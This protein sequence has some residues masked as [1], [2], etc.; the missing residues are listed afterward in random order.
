MKRERT[1]QPQPGGTIIEATAGNTGLGLASIAAQKGYS[2]IPGGTR[3]KMSYARK[4]ST[5][6][7]WVPSGTDAFDVIKGH[8]AYYQDYAR[9]LASELPGAFYIDQFNNEANLLAHRT[10]TA[11]ELFEQ[12][13]GGSTPSWWAWDQAARCGLQAWFAEHS[14]HTEFVLA[15]PAGSVSGRPGNWT[16]PRRGLRW[17]RELAKTLFRHWP[18]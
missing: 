14:P 12:L 3:D 7:R 9:R 2:L 1:G 11:P 4:S 18:T 13:N 5:F 6:A 10:T 15:D 16:L 8:P 17:L